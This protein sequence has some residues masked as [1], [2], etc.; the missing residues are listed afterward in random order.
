MLNKGA[1]AKMPFTKRDAS[2]IFGVVAEV[3]EVILN[4]LIIITAII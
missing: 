4:F 3:V 1:I 2:P